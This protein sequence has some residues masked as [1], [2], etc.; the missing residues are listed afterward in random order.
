MVSI[1]GVWCWAGCSARPRSVIN[2]PRQPRQMREITNGWLEDTS[3]LLPSGATVNAL[4]HCSEG[5]HKRRLFP[6]DESERADQYAALYYYWS[7]SG[8]Y[9]YSLSL[10]L[11]PSLF[12]SSFRAGLSFPVPHNF[13][14]HLI[15]Y[16]LPP[17]HSPLPLLA[18]LV[19]GEESA[20]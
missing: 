11:S 5:K 13:Y 19:C 17:P 18:L 12:L 1:P 9:N 4:P 2:H 7:S 3:W 14:P 8:F 6:S 10:S 15:C 20:H 16:P